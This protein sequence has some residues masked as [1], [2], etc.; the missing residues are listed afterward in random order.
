MKTKLLLLLLLANFSIY[1]QTTAIP[2]V[3]FEKKLIS[4][5]I[6]SGPT[7]GKV[8]T[9]NITNL[10]S[11]DI[12][13]SNITNLAGIEAFTSLTS[14]DFSGNKLASVNLS[15]NINL[16]SLKANGN[17]LT[18]L[19]VTSNTKLRSLYCQNNQLSTINVS[20]NIA[21]EFLVVNSNLL[22]GLD[23]S[24][25]K[26]LNTLWC[27]GNEIKVLDLT[28]NTKLVNL[29]CSDNLITNIDV[30]ANKA[31]Q[32]IDCSSN[33]LTFLNLKNG[34]NSNFVSFSIG[35]KDNPS[36]TC[37]QVDDETYSTNN[38][39]S[40]KDVTATFKTSCDNGLLYTSIPDINFENKL[41][42]L[43]IDS[44]APDGKVLTSK[45]ATVTTL[46]INNSNISDLTGIQDFTALTELSCDSNKLTI[47][48]VSKNLL[49]SNLNCS[50]NK[51]SN[52]DLSENVF[53]DRINCSYNEM[54][55]LN[56][57]GITRL[58][59]L[60]CYNNNITSLNVSQNKNLIDFRCFN[61]KITSLNLASNTELTD[62]YINSNLI[63]T[64][65]LTNNVNLRYL[66]C[67]NNLMSTLK[68][69]HL[70][71]LVELSVSNI[72][73]LTSIDIS[74]NV[75]LTRFD[76]T[77]SKFT[78]LDLSKN[79]QLITLICNYSELTSLDLSNKTALKY[80][81]CSNNKLTSL[82]VSNS[83]HLETLSFNSNKITSIDLSK[84]LL[85]TNLQASSNNLSNLDLSKNPRLISAYFS[86]NNLLKLNL[87]NGKNTL[88]N[89][90]SLSFTSNPNL[91]CI[92]VDDANYS[93]T[94]WSA[95]KDANASYNTNC[96]QYTAIPDV[97]FEDKLIELNIDTDGKNGLVLNSNIASLTTL[98]V[99][100]S[101]IK[102]LSGIEEFK[103][104]KDLNVSGN[105]LSN[106]DLSK[107]TS[108]NSLNSLNNTKLT[109]IQ[110]A[111]VENA[112]ANWTILKDNI[113]SINTNCTQFTLIPDTNFEAK[114][115]ALGYD[116][117]G[118]NG[119][120]VTNNIKNL[121]SLDISY[122]S[123]ANLTGI[124]DFTDLKSLN[125]SVNP[126]TKLDLS[127][128]INLES[129]SCGSNSGSTNG[130]GSG[131][132]TSLDLSKN[133]NLKSLN[134]ASNK[135][136]TL[137]ILA[138]TKL[139]YLNFGYNFIKNIDLPNSLTSITFEAN[140]IESI[141]LSGNKGLTIVDGDYA[142]LKA[143]D[144][145]Q[146]IKLKIL[147]ASR[148]KVNT[149][150]ISKNT[151]LTYIVCAENSELLNLNLKNGQ[152]TNFLIFEGQNS[153][154]KNPKLTC[155][156]VDDASFSNNNW[157]N[158]KDATSS[159]SA[160]CSFI[161]P[162]TLIPDVIFE[163]KLISLGIDK[164]GENGKIN[165]VSANKITSLDL[166]NS[167][168][169]DL[170]GIEAFISLLSLDCNFNSLSTIDVSNNKLLTKLALHSNNLTNLDL[171]SNTE[172]FN[173]TFSSNQISTIDLSNNKKLHYIVADRNLLTNI[174]FSANTELEMI[175]CGT[176]KLSTLNVSNLPN[177][178]DLNCTDTN[179]SK[180]DVSSNPKL[181]N[182]YFNNANL[183]TLDL[184]QNL[185]LKRLNV[186]NNQLT[187]LDLS[188]NPVLELIFVEF[189]PLTT[190]NVQNGNNKN[191]ILPSKT[192]KN[193]ATG[194]ATSFLQNL[195]LSCIQVD[196]VAFSNANWSH[197]KETLA[198]YSAKCTLGV[199]ESIFDKVVMYP[200]PTKGE[201]NINNITLEKATVYNSLG[202]LVKSFV[203]NSGDSNNTINLS[204]LPRGVYF[205]YLIN[206][207][208][209]S[210]KKVIVE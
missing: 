157:A 88:L 146:N 91:T 16:T 55:V 193:T 39:S 108:L 81:D 180:L 20:A 136:T 34:N 60:A 202:Q 204:G 19:S 195:K 44:G 137:N 127:K 117:D 167:N 110:V 203:F 164:D 6:D 116:T 206:G 169:S 130:G 47:L 208:A 142:T 73:D 26:S 42:A 123:I 84:N 48:D 133:V 22:T 66:S 197:I 46:S 2:D 7:D 36:L 111:N 61:N 205:I 85:L 144:L 99:S 105:L 35:F 175:Y 76:C 129:L 118:L 155:I 25:L 92:E 79:I 187:T 160:S 181:A 156:Q 31:L 141:D 58:R 40:Y 86:S 5:G 57:S 207:D 143:L 18:A 70:K 188:H 138:C 134:C 43:G 191:F 163:K 71:S 194:D 152:N 1:A 52:L 32:S 64:L 125:C 151:A 198:T 159:Y 112:T 106:L 201:V 174:D 162:Y 124:E 150:D 94:N 126:I 63:T 9:A 49:L 45:V 196:D 50:Y 89:K 121:T 30:S 95:L 8:I 119:K 199:E 153:F 27:Y 178:Q 87:K 176:N 51:I 114:L 145:S 77:F 101:N 185:L 29:D 53:L 139:E 83:P 103:A 192:G 90:N 17:K 115:I 74:E 190:L 104:L 210:A 148:T 75:L 10:T 200:N 147:Y 177:L 158:L 93:N 120:V 59:T 13:S 3:E 165:N 170:K 100:N 135:I 28:P 98:N 4:L 69:S 171:K 23:V 168:I 184:S 166:S 154:K 149:L 131:N 172:L 140:P 56:V 72:P 209:A 97:A 161:E 186:S 37:I 62:L 68:T 33:K 54:T 96:N 179:I 128:N 113:A 183:T 24:A 11:L 109:C 67:G 21:L 38:W 173:L 132:L 80:V 182:L 82:N 102:N 78:A 189:N 14:L 122:S 65:D 15:G 41:I 107:N 12:S